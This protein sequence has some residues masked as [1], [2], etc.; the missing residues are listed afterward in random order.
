MTELEIKPSAGMLMRVAGLMLCA[1]AI[2]AVLVGLLT[3]WGAGFFAHKTN[4]KT[5][6]PDATGLEVDSPVRMDGIQI[7]KI[8]S[9]SISGRLDIQ[10]AVLV[11]LRVETKY[12]PDIPADSMTSIGSDTLIG[13]KYVDIDEGKN[14]MPVAEGGELRSEPAAQAADKADLIYGLQDS[15]RK[16]DTMMQQISSP[17]TQIGRYIVGEKEYNQALRYVVDFDKQLQTVL[18]TDNVVGQAFFTMNVYNK[19][20]KVI[21]QTDDTLQAMQRGEGMAGRLYASDELYN[22]ALSKV[23]DVR[24]SIADA[25]AQIA[26]IAPELRDDE[27]YVKL[28]REL[29]SMDEKLAALNRGEGRG[30]ELLTNPQLYESLTGSLKKLQALLKDFRENPRKYLRMKVF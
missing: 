8:R 12:L 5:Y 11:V 24:K 22:S 1:L 27:R 29:A 18:S 21:L 13:N 9:I 6:M 4:L 10:R 16:V 2:T 28:Q 19:V 15:L 30:G 17:D 26:K 25:R 7:G 14:P 3:D 23:S 20:E